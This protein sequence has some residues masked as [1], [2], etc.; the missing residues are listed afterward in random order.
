MNRGTYIL[1]GVCWFS[2]YAC[3]NESIV[4]VTLASRNA[5]WLLD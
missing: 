3:D 1:V 2:V 5:S 4:H